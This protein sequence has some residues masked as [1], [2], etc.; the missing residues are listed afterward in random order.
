MAVDKELTEFAGISWEEAVSRLRSAHGD[1]YEDRIS[2]GASLQRYGHR[3]GIDVPQMVGSEAVLQ[4]LIR[5]QKV[6]PQNA[7]DLIQKKVGD[8][9][10]FETITYLIKSFCESELGPSE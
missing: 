8:E 7:L 4:P 5:Y 6:S 3:Q 1:S 9:G 2:L 10:D